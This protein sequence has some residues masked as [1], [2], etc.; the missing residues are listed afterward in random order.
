MTDLNSSFTKLSKEILLEQTEANLIT[1]GFQ[2]ARMLEWETTEKQRLIALYV[3]C[4]PVLMWD[5]LHQ[6]RKFVPGSL[7]VT[8]RTNK[9]YLLIN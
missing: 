3:P 9:C 1:N 7:R 4:S 8:A 2:V 6:V 5:R